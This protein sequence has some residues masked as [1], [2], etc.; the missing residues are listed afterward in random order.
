MDD[1]PKLHQA[2]VD[3]DGLLEVLSKNLYSTP[4]V[5][6]RELVQNAHDSCLR[7]ELEDPNDFEPAIKIKPD[8]KNGTLT[9][10]DNGAGLTSDEVERYLATLG[11][12]YTRVLRNRSG[13]DKLIGAFGLGF[14]SA[15]IVSTRVD[16]WTTSYQTP[17]QTWH[18]SSRNGQRFTLQPATGESVGTRV[19]LQLAQDFVGLANTPEVEAILS[20]YCCLLPLPVYLDQEQPRHINSRTPPWRL[21]EQ[22]DPMTLERRRF[23]FA[24]QFESYFRPLCTM[25]VAQNDNGDAVGL[26]WIHDQGSFATS[27]NRNLAVFVRGMLINDEERDLLPRWAGFVG[28][29]IESQKLV[30]TRQSGDVA[31]G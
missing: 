17:D 20:R 12:G 9:I 24:E 22:L 14:L 11:A 1:A 26:L 30:P 27:D 3:F 18:F 29:I 16:V 5:T 21:T 13:S 2:N 15:Y 7:R 10:I 31:K 6:L 25:P 23:E 8:P 28:G 19:R 4:E